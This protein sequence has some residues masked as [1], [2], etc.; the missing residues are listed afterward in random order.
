MS[1]RGIFN[2][3]ANLPHDCNAIA[4]F[5]VGKTSTCNLGVRTVTADRDTFLEQYENLQNQWRQLATDRGRQYLKYLAPRA[6]VDFVLVGKMTSISKT[7]A[8]K[9]L[10]GKFPRVGPPGYNLMISMGDLILNYGAHRHLCRPGERYY[11]TD[12]GKCAV[13][14][15]E[16]KGRTLHEEFTAWYPMLLDELALVAKPGATVIPIGSAAGAFLH[17]QPGFP[18]RLTT[19]ILHW[20]RAA[21]SAAKMASSLFPREWNEYRRSTSWQDLRSSTEE[22]LSEAGLGHHMDAVNSL[23][24]DKFT[25]FHAHYMFTYTKEMPLRRPDTC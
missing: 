5:S 17:A 25:E 13:P 14:P 12:L 15:H 3:A 16:A 4:A 23:H 18:Y 7:D 19:S 24:K 10:P 22:I 6:P 1:D 8:A 11:L 2:T 21:V 9:T 20:S